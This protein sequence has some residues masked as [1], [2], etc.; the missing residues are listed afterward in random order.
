LVRLLTHAPEIWTE[1]RKENYES[2]NIYQSNIG[3]SIDFY[4]V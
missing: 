3:E 1:L 2:A 4:E